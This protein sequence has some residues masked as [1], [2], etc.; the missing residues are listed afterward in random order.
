MKTNT[1]HRLLDD[2]NHNLDLDADIKSLDMPE[3]QILEG[4]L[5]HWQQICQHHIRT[6]QAEARNAKG[7]GEPS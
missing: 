7:E 2:L 6:R 5:Y 3:L 1:I 4:L